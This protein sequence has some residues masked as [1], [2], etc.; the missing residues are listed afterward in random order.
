MRLGL[1]MAPYFTTSFYP[2]LDKLLKIA[3]FT[4]LLYFL[5]YAN[6]IFSLCSDISSHGVFY[7]LEKEILYIDFLSALGYF[8]LGNPILY[9][10]D[11][12]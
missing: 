2:Y 1:Q 11:M 9:I 4:K 12:N 5:L 7:T 3:D 6:F 8:F 10:T